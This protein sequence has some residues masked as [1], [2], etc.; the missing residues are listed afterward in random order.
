[1]IKADI[2]NVKNVNTYAL[3]NL[4]SYAQFRKDYAMYFK[5]T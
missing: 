3:T 5:N 4:N 2:N 1:M